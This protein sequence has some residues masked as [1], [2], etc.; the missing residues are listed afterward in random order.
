MGNLNL[1]AIALPESLCPESAVT[2]DLPGA[3]GLIGN[4]EGLSRF[5]RGE[6]L[7]ALFGIAAVD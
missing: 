2:V 6:T 3:E 7:R 1:L 4:A 5:Q